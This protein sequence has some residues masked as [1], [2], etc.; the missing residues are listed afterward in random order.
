MDY[1]IQRLRQVTALVA[2]LAL[3]GCST[4]DIGNSSAKSVATGSTGGGNAQNVNDQLE[5]C[6]APLGTL[7]LVE[8]VES[9]WYRRVRDDLKVESIKPVMRL[10]VQQS[11]CFVVIERGDNGMAAMKRERELAASGELRNESSFGKGQMVAADYTLSPSIT[12][13]NSS[14]KQLGGLLGGVVGGLIG[15]FSYKEAST[16]LML[17]DNRSSVQL[18][19][20][21]GSAKGT[22]ISGMPWLF[23]DAMPGLAGFTKTTDGKVLIA[24]FMDAYNGVVKGV[25]GY[26]AQ[27]VK[28]GLGAGGNLKVQGSN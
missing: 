23:G 19:A 14:G 3:S 16:M 7:A 1:S 5:R 26:K 15:N 8:D 21:E 18:A 24:A 10:L 17:V 13:E 2:G 11:N 27:E 28:G 9:D 12:F 4:M 6:D 20:A 25:K 22:N